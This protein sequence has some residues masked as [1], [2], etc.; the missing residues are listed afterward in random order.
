MDLSIPLKDDSNEDCVIS[1]ILEKMPKENA[2]ICTIVSS[3]P[4]PCTIT[5]EVESGL[6]TTEFLPSELAPSDDK[7]MSW[8]IDKKLSV[9]FV[10]KGNLTRQINSPKVII[11]GKEHTA[12]ISEIGNVRRSKIT[13]LP[14]THVAMFRKFLREM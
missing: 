9:S 12:K 4:V 1:K 7:E 11:N 10:L 3:T 2:Y 6:K 14:F 5:N 8:D 13:T